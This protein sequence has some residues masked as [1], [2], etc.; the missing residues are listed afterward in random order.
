VW[1]FS[2]PNRETRDA[3][4]RRAGPLRN[5]TD[6]AALIPDPYPLAKAIALTALERKESR[7]PHLRTDCPET[8]PAL[9][10]VHV[11]F[12]PDGTVRREA[13]R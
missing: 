2:P 5:P 6:L 3:V 12:S 9:D 7:G 1:R 10:G 13:W 8:D 4:W 11:V